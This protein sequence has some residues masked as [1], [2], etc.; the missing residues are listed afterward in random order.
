MA[1][2]V[3]VILLVGTVLAG[4]LGN[5]DE[6]NGVGD[7]TG[8]ATYSGTWAGSS[9]EMGD[10]DGTWEYEVDF[11]A[12]TVTG[13]FTGDLWGDI[14]GSVDDGVLEADGK[15]A[16]GTV[17]WEGDIS[18]DGEDVSGTWEAV[19]EDASGT[20]SGDL[21]EVIDDNDD[22]DNGYIGTGKETFSGTWEGEDALGQAEYEGTWEFTVDWETNDVS[23]FFQGDSSA[24]ISGSVSHGEID[25][26]GQAALG[27]V[28]W[29]GT[30]STDGTAI[31]GNWEIEAQGI[32]GYSGTW[33]GQEGEL[34]NDNG[35]ENGEDENGE[36][37]P[38]LPDEDQESGEE[39]AERYPD[40]VILSHSKATV[41]GQT[42]ITITYGTMD[43]I[44]DVVNWYK[45]EL[46]DPY[47]EQ[48]QGGVTS[49]YFDL[50][51]EQS[52]MLLVEISENDYTSIEV[53]YIQG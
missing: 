52:E 34:E 28:S 27:F 8:T 6:E 2:A 31:S 39:P 18:S 12:G 21:D 24:D 38:V 23:G 49:L 33:S 1:I 5:D 43:G 7:L 17:E 14:T 25:A 26:E 19:D 46:G 3:V 30:F 50:D 37:E 45:G 41:G 42:Y 20:W 29:W 11:D 36:E 53:E 40:S 47:A 9:A 51:G 16:F 10:I 32:V 13:S 48:T 22:D 44:D 15:A 35:E 4:C